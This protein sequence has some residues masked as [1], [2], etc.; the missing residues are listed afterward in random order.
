MFFANSFTAIAA[1]CL[2]L[3][4]Q[5]YAHD[6]IAPALDVNST[7]VCSDAQRP[8]TAKPC[9]NAALT[10]IDISTAVTA[11]ANRSF[12]ATNTN[13]VTA[14]ISADGTGRNI[15]LRKSPTSMGSQQLIFQIL[16]GTTCSGGVS[17][18]KCLVSFVTAGAQPPSV[19]KD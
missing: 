14:M 16:A 17:K 12:A 6:A 2:S 5:A 11:A 9:S 15:C 7:P 10:G 8:S 4:L 13:F 19:R 3:L 18:S 1:L